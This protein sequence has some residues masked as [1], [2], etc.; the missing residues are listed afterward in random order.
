ME[1]TELCEYK[2][3]TWQVELDG[4][5]KYYINGS[6]VSEFEL[7]K[8]Q[9][10]SAAELGEIKSADTLRKAKKRALYLL[11][12]RLMCRGELTAKLTKTYGEQ[13]AE[14]AAD[15]V[16]ELG[17]VNDEEYAP[18]L[19]EY[20]IKRKRWG[21]RRARYEMLR[22]GLDRGLV[23]NTLAD[24]PGDEIDE[25]LTAL[26]G[27]K[28]AGKIRDYDDRRRTIAALARRGYDL[29]AIKRCI[30]AFLESSEDN[31]EFDDVYDDYE[32]Q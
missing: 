6:V 11:G 28:Y 2:G 22:R 32:E 21:V 10:V 20:L 17:Y 26:I 1:I 4:E 25:E 3:D 8:G 23:E 12:E 9:T 30:N 29:G 5:R 18:K 15:Y 13:V 7:E 19:A 24:I 14:E 27:K 16:C 31:G